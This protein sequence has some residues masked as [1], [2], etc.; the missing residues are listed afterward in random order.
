[1]PTWREGQARDGARYRTLDGLSRK[2]L[3]ASRWSSA[4]LVFLSYS[5]SEA[6]DGIA[7]PS[8]TRRTLHLVV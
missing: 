5:F 7:A 3:A 6:S 8:G 2:A 4:L 1:M